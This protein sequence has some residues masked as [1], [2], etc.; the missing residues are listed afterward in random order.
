MIKQKQRSYSK[1]TDLNIK[2]QP[3][4]LSVNS[5]MVSLVLTGKSYESK[6]YENSRLF[7]RALT[8]LTQGC[9][10]VHWWNCSLDL[11]QILKLSAEYCWKYLGVFVSAREDFLDQ[12]GYGSPLVKLITRKYIQ[13]R[14]C[15][16]CHWNAQLKNGQNWG[17]RLSLR[18]CSGSLSFAGLDPRCRPTHHLACHGCGRRHTY[19]VEEDRHGC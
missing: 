10:Q 5:Q 12:T 18:L 15:T 17:R 1:K 2:I 9:R 11:R 8:S 19:K 3:T 13:Q 14:E 16:L 4:K 6:R 7:A